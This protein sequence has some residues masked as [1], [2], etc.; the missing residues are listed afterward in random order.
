ME[1]VCRGLG[2]LVAEDLARADS[3]LML[4]ISGHSEGYIIAYSVYKRAIGLGIRHRMNISRVCCGCLRRQINPRM[5]L[6][7]RESAAVAAEA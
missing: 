7:G 4:T 3:N 5:P 1:D 6:G 2:G